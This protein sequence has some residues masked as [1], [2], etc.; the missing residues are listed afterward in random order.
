MISLGRCG[1]PALFVSELGKDRVGRFIQSFMEENNLSSEFIY[2]FEDGQSPV[3]LAFLDENRNAVYAFYKDFPKKRLDISFPAIN[4]ND[5][6]VLSSYFAVN[7]A[8]RDK[9]TGLLKYA[10]AQKAIIY[11]DINFRRAHAGEQLQLMDNFI[12]NF[13]FSTIIRCSDEDLGVLFPGF[14]VQEIYERYFQPQRKSLIITRSEKEIG[15]K[16]PVFKK[17]YAVEAITPVSAIGAG[18]NFNA[19]FVYGLIKNNVTLDNLNALPENEW[20]PL[21]EMAKMF[22][23]E[24]CSAMDNY[25]SCEFAKALTCRY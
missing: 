11:Y 15:L 13:R 3:S 14:T 6:V 18:D 1:V 17:E 16:T 24:A 8:L 23:T 21:I 22:A 4:E 25:V 19:G 10:R 2:F 5:V 7:P 9:V 12:E 20:R